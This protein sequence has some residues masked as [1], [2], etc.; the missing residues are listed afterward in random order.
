[1]NRLPLGLAFVG[2]VVSLGSFIAEMETS[3]ARVELTALGRGGS[4][5]IFLAIAAAFLLERDYQSAGWALQVLA[6]AVAIA[7]LVVAVVKLYTASNNP[8]GAT[9]ALP[10]S[11]EAAS[12]A[13]AALAF[14]LTAARIHS[15]GAKAF[16]ACAVGGTVGCFAYAVS[17]TTGFNSYVWYENAAVLAALAA[18]CAARMETLGPAGTPTVE[19]E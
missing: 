1:M 19:A 7:F 11:G 17:L 2:A 15:F 4:V 10:W 3:S 6:A 5:L 16:L 13:F 18:A 8:F 14:G 9:E 12:M